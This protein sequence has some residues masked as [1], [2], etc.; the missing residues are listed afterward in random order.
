VHS[1][2]PEASVALLWARQGLR[3]VRPPANVEET[4]FHKG[5]LTLLA[6]RRRV[7]AGD[8]DLKV[9]LFTGEGQT[10]LKLAA[11]AFPA[12]RMLVFTEGGGSFCWCFDERRAIWNHVK[13]RFGGG[14]PLL[15]TVQRLA[16]ALLNPLL[17]FIA[18]IGLLL[19]HAG[20]LLHRMLW[21]FR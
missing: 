18:F 17:S 21:R 20:L 12:R 2:F 8:Y 15:K 5:V 14:Q 3:P 7:R 4:I 13:W 6:E 19:W 11:F 9:V 16:V 10:L 1:R